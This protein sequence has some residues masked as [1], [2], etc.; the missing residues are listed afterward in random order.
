MEILSYK[1]VSRLEIA[2]PLLMVVQCTLC[3]DPQYYP[4]AVLYLYHLL[5]LVPLDP[6]V[7][8]L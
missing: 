7:I 3:L 1:L 5:M 6:V 4:P 2:L 8:S